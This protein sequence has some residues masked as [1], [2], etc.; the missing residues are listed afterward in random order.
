MAFREFCQTVLAKSQQRYERCSFCTYELREAHFADFRSEQVALWR[1]HGSLCVIESRNVEHLDDF[2]F[3]EWCRTS[4]FDDEQCSVNS[5]WNDR[6]TVTVMVPQGGGPWTISSFEPV[7]PDRLPG[8]DWFAYGIPW[9]ERAYSELVGDADV[10]VL[11]FSDEALDD[12]HA[13]KAVLVV[14]EISDEKLFRVKYT[15]HFSTVHG[16]CLR[17]ESV[18]AGEPDDLVRWTMSYQESD[19]GVWVLHDVGFEYLSNGEVR[20]TGRQEFRNWNFDEVVDPDRVRLTWYGLNEPAGMAP[21]SEPTPDNSSYW[22]RLLLIVG[23]LFAVTLVTG[24]IAK[25]RTKATDSPN[26]AADPQ[27]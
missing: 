15:A 10:D 7:T 13:K 16:Q 22:S 8:T 2:S 12:V 24:V 21:A 14:P 20:T 17:L 19:P 9:A 5:F 23:A 11:G 18:P 4:R 1:R 3:A 25:R 6:Y 26:D 27:A